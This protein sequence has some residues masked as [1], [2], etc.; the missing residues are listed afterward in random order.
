MGNNISRFT[1]LHRIRLYD[2][3]R[4]ADLSL[5][6]LKR[7]FFVLERCTLEEPAKHFP[8]REEANHLS[9]PD[10]RELFDAPV[11]HDRRRLDEV[12]IF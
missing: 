4:K 8:T 6:L 9:V 5:F 7:R 10:Y 3:E 2:S 11:H 1:G 12:L